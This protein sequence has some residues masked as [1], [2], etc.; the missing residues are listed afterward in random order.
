MHPADQGQPVPT[1]HLSYPVSNSAFLR[2]EFAQ[3]TVSDIGNSLPHL[4]KS[5]SGVDF[6]HARHR[7]PSCIPNREGKKK[8]GKHPA[9]YAAYWINVLSKTVCV[10]A[11]ETEKIETQF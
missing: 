3:F 9:A 4:Q 8:K 11:S 1:S 6:S 7:R 2:L 5:S 10:I